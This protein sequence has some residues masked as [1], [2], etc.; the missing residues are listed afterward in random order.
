MSTAS[1]QQPSVLIAGS[2]FGGI[3]LALELKRAGFEDFTL[4]EKADAEDAGGNTLWSPSYM[5]LDAPDRVAP[6]GRI[7]RS[8]AVARNAFHHP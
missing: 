3:G 8:A 2:G 6:A 5:R 7:L 1:S 4:L